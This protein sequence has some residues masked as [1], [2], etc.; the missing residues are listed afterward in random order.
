MIDEILRTSRAYLKIAP[1]ESQYLYF[2]DLLSS[3]VNLFPNLQAPTIKIAYSLNKLCELFPYKGKSYLVYDQYLGQ[4]FNKL[5]RIVYHEGKNEAQAYLSKLLGEE[6]YLNNEI[7]YSICFLINHHVNRSESS[8]MDLPLNFIEKKGKLV[9]IQES[10]VFYHELAHLIVKNHPEIITKT[11]SFLNEN[12]DV[13]LIVSFIQEKLQ[14]SGE[15]DHFVEE[16]ASDFTAMDLTF[17]FFKNLPEIE[18]E[19][20]IE[21]IS[22]AFLYLR[23]LY[24]LKTKAASKHTSKLGAISKLRY[25]LIRRYFSTNEL[26]KEDWDKAG[27]LVD[28]YDNWE[29]MIDMV[30]VLYLNDELKEHLHSILSKKRDEVFNIETLYEFIGM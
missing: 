8:V 20:I 18:S 16:V 11:T 22:L 30:M 9:F 21:S 12:E 27:I 10:F 13:K 17:K 24:D 2:D 4:S 7:E 26:Y 29:E 28:A 15:F 23:T 6:F 25:N 1:N 19:V 3:A 14:E 5:N